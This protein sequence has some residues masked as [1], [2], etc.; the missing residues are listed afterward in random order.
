M[1]EFHKPQEQDVIPVDITE[2]MKDSY[3]DYAMS[4]IV[5]RAIPDVRDGLKPVH[6]RIL[7]A[8]HDMG[9]RPDRPH[10]KSAR[11]VGEVLGKY[12]PHGNRPV[13]DAV[14]RMA[15]SFAHRY[16]LVDGHGNFGSIDG[17]EPAAMRY[18][19][20]RL[21]ELAMEMMRDMDK[22]TVDFIPNFDD[23]LEEPDV[24][25][26]KY[27]NLLAN[28]SSGIAVG[29]A[30]NIPPHNLTEV[31]DGVLAMIDD[32]D[33][34]VEELRQIIPGPDFP[35]GGLIV[36]Q[37]GIKEAY[38][39]GRGIITM[40][41]KCEIVERA[42][43]GSRIEVTEIPY[44]LKKSKLIEKIAELVRSDQLEGI[45]DL[46][47][48]TDREG[49]R[50]AI[51]VKAHSNP[52]VVLNRL[53]KNTPLQQS[54]GIIMLALVDGRPRVL[55]L[56]E[57]L[58]HYL[59]HQREVITRRTKYDLERAEARA[60][61]LEGLQIALDHIDAVISLIRG[62]D[63]VEEAREGLMENFQLTER[64]ARAILNMRLQRLTGLEREKIDQEYA[65]LTED[66]EH[67]RN[68]LADEGLVDEI[69]KAEIK[70]I[71]EKYGDERKTRITVDMDAD[72][73]TEDLIAKEDVVVTLSREDYIKRMPLETYRS[74]QRGGRGIIG[75]ETKEGDFVEEM[76]VTTTHHHIL[77]F[78]NKGLVYR[79]RVFQ[80][81][82]AGR[83]ARGTA[84]VNL[85]ELDEDEHISAVVPVDEFD[86][87]YLIAS[88][89]NGLVKR[90]E[91]QAYDTR[92]QGLIA[93]DLREGDE[94]VDVKRTPENADT[95]LVTA[96]GMSIRFHQREVRPMGR[97]AQGVIG[98]RLEGDD[99]VVGMGVVH[100]ETLPA[101]VLVVTENG[102]GKRTPISQYRPQGR[103][104][105]GIKTLD[106]T[107]RNGPI[108]GMKVVKPDDEIMVISAHGII[109]RTRVEEISRM[110]R[111]TQGVLVM[112]L[113]KQDQ[114]VSLARVERNV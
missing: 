114:V 44:Q 68:I 9:L 37:E 88:T 38:N 3:I 1:P 82:E 48:E 101:D 110:G 35:T 77:F 20:C 87:G 14:V 39:S 11:V 86:G 50:I 19:E 2:E 91:L 49:L 47:D 78:T 16:P 85:I 42:G 80:I 109:L 41:A 53:Y 106:L 76:F 56:R 112:R 27:P 52:R 64:Q 107:H 102:Y 79:K 51:D 36:G 61:I 71:R 8:M 29:M 17:D 54:F 96:Q 92:W 105:K 6:R 98:I 84:A 21:S 7:Y 46:R 62:S 99:E 90:T 5:S 45:S 70:E 55:S 40:R 30:T 65:Q 31:I 60:H 12:H 59:E 18:T 34:G 89:K 22:D 73:E 72:L 113:E 74:Q 95:L 75:V 103:A 69:I 43:G 13:Y 23:E 58:Y 83:R 67:Y 25:P 57:M 63:T 81:P 111:N 10:R 33:I 24:L 97:D 93:V 66:I 4:V 26:A 108:K 100:E 94:L 32:P 104:G 28:G 15:Q